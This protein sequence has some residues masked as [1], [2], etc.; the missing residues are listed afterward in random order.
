MSV[1]ASPRISWNLQVMESALRLLYLYKNT[2]LGIMVLW[3][4]WCGS[5]CLGLLSILLREMAPSFC[6]HFMSTVYVPGMVLGFKKTKS[7]WVG[8]FSVPWPPAHEKPGAETCSWGCWKWGEGVGS[9]RSPLHA[10]SSESPGAITTTA[11]C[12]HLRCGRSNDIKGIAW[13]GLLPSV[14]ALQSSR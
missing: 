11:A 14:P 5:I 13:E 2:S 3:I 1:W 8:E 4:R 9:S 6:R 10:P 12:R 7:L